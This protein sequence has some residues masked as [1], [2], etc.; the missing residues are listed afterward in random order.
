MHRLLLHH[1]KLVLVQNSVQSLLTDPGEATR[2]HTTRRVNW[3]GHQCRTMIATTAVKI[4]T[5]LEDI[6]PYCPTNIKKL[7]ILVH[8]S[9]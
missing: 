7:A 8:F 3:F 6:V 1:R 2:A 5:N 4:N 9:K